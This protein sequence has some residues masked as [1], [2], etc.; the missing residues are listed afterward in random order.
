MNHS[1]KILVVDDDAWVLTTSIQMIASEI[2]QAIIDTASTPDQCLARVQRQ[3]YDLIF[4]DIS[5]SASGFEGLA[6]LPDIRDSQPLARIFMI[7]GHDDHRTVIES[8]ALGAFDFIS[9]NRDE[10]GAL[11]A[12]LRSYFEGQ[13]QD[14]RDAGDARRIANAMGIVY[15]S[16][17]M[18]EV[19]RQMVVARRS[20]HVPVLITG[21][22]GVGKDVIAMAIAGAKAPRQPVAVDCGAIPET[23]AES[24]L[25]G[26][27]RGA[28]TGAD[29]DS[30]GRF[31]QAH[32][33]DLFLDEIGNLRRSVQ[34]K[35]LRAIQ[36]GEITALGAKKSRKVDVRII[37]ATNED[38][39]QM[40]TDGRF[41]LDLLERLRGIWIKVPPLRARPS[42]IPILVKKFIASANQT[43]ISV[44]PSCLTLLKSYSW[45]GNV[46]EL[47]HVLHEAVANWTGGPLTTRHL[48]HTFRD[49][50]ATELR[51]P[52]SKGPGQSQHDPGRY[53]IALQ[54]LL[55]DAQERFLAL[56]LRDRCQSGKQPVSKKALATELG[57]SRNTLDSYIKR[58]G[59]SIEFHPS[60][61][62]ATEKRSG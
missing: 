35:L 51:I 44:A 2:G 12:I 9:K 58:F 62:E 32:Q 34:D 48:S 40:V 47:E 54:G 50:L 1:A 53:H 37:A 18:A 16:A 15:E 17:A 29:E 36:T 11:T 28:F 43:D 60:L 57:I 52:N 10:F 45:P 33:G 4:L 26:H 46:R 14:E 7:S 22:T 56:Y 25:F 59:L 20:R 61:D 31:V 42:D 41:R 39:D 49:R 24:E 27:M 3:Q 30:P 38:L 21:E 5:L 23:L 13:K 6:L 8:H 55:S 19:F